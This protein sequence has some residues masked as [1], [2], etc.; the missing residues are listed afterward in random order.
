MAGVVVTHPRRAHD[1]A[2]TPLLAHHSVCRG[3]GFH[4]AGGAC[5][6]RRARRVARGLNWLAF[7]VLFALCAATSNASLLVEVVR[8][9]RYS[10]AD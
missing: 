7:A 2:D 10:P 1:D 4:C 5:R 6:V 8:D 9:E 3:I